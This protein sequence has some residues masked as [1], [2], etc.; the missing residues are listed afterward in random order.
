MNEAKRELLVEQLNF[1]KTLKVIEDEQN[2]K[3][4]IKENGEVLVPAEYAMAKI[5]LR[6]NKFYPF[7]MKPVI[8]VLNHNHKEA[9][10]GPNLKMS[11]FTPYGEINGPFRGFINNMINTTFFYQ[12]V[13]IERVTSENIHIYSYKNRELNPIR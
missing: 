1:F 9:H 4:V 13:P 11:R 5:C 12:D 2:R 10:M 3:G 7:T 6:V 8:W